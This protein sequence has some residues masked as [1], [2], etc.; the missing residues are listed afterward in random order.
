MPQFLYISPTHIKGKKPVAWKNFLKGGYI[1]LGWGHI[2]YSSYTLDKILAH[3]K[4]AGYNNTNEALDAHKK[5]NNLNVGDIVAVNNASQGIFG[6]GVVQSGYKY[7]KHIHNPEGNCPKND[8]YSHYRE[9]K[10]IVKE[11]IS[12]DKL[13]NKKYNEKGISRGTVGALYN[14]VPRH[15]SDLL[16]EHNFIIAENAKNWEGDSELIG[17]E[18][19]LIK[20]LKQHKYIER[21]LG[22]R[23]RFKYKYSNIKTCPLCGLDSM[24]KYKISPI[25]FLELHHLTPLSS[26]KSDAN[27]ITKESDVVLL[28]PNCH[29]YAHDLLR[30][31]SNKIFKFDDIKKSFLK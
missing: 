28:C 31:S 1:A 22:F 5:F 8:F 2:D 29:R 6:I 14:F 15:I 13:S 12:K 18:G 23:E 9:V 26:R 21:D 24:K 27:S 11:Y 4:K 3:I 17:I 20:E 19:K 30:V 25:N 10:W 16:S 7:K